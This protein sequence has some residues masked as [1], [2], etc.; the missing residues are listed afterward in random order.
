MIEQK[1]QIAARHRYLPFAMYMVFIGIDELLRFCQG[2]NLITFG[3]TALYYIHPVKAVSVALLL[4]LFK[5]NYME[6]K[7]RDLADIPTTFI[8]VAVGLLVFI[9]WI[10]MPWTLDGS[11][12][13]QGFNPTLF[14]DQ[15]TQITMTVA[16]IAGAVLVVP[17]MEELFWRSYLIR[18]L[19][20]KNFES[21]PIG[22]FSWESFLITT[23]LF[24]F[25][26]NFIYAGI[27][28]GIIYNLLLYKTRS[29]VHC[30]LSHAVTNLALAVYVLATGKWYFW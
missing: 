7:L 14:P 21:I 20:A 23:V 16:R 13:H 19:I 22:A 15:I 10:N 6:L 11:N 9:L 8:S 1:I 2:H 17:I 5:D 24:G 18:H 27:V 29:I 3:A 12:T 30:T 28:A 4:Y 26:H 25:E